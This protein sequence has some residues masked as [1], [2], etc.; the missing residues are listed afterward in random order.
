MEQKFVNFFKKI[1]QKFVKKKFRKNSNK[2]CPK[3]FR[4]DQA[5]V[6]QKTFRNIKSSKSLSF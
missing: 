4:K 6:C 2:V 1:E 5:K 3:T